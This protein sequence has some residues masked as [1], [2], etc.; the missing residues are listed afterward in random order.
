MRYQHHVSIQYLENA[1]PLDDD[2]YPEDD[3]ISPDLYDDY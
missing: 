3:I 2:D 1:D